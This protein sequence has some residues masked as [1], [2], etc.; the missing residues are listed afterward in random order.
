VHIIDLLVVCAVV[1]V[2]VACGLVLARQ[3][4][5][6]HAA[7]S[8]PMAIRTR[9]TRWHYGVARYADAELHWY[10]ALGLGT[11][12]SRVWQ[13]NEL[14]VVSRRTPEGSELQSLPEAA[15]IVECKDGDTNPT[16]ALG[17]SAFTGFVSWLEAS[18]PLP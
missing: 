1:V 14:V 9:G 2:L 8:I 6:L 12:P 3:R 5:M 18:A 7:G 11:R 16:L 17:E 4:F 10:R 15:V 13:R